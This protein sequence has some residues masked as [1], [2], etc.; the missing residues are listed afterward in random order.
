[1]IFIPG[2]VPSSKNSKIFTRGR[3][4]IWSKAAS[5]YRKNSKEAFL[6]NKK[7]FLSMLN[8]KEKP[9]IICFHF[10]RATKHKYDFVNVVQ[11]IQDLMVEYGYIEDDNIDIMLP[12]PFRMGDKYSSYDKDNP[13]V[14]IK[15]ENE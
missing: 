8:G 10:V 14:Y 2:A 11:T 5:L 4:L 1:M 9:Y 12:F 13:G 15:I 6:A 7:D 3:K